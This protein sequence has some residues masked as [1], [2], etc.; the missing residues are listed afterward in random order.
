MIGPVEWSLDL[1]DFVSRIEVAPHGAVLAGS[2]SGSAVIVDSGTGTAIDL[3]A[4]SLGVLSGGW[5][6]DAGLLATGGHDGVVRIHSADGQQRAE[7][8]LDGWVNA[9]AWGPRPELLAVAAGRSLR[10]ID[11][12]GQITRSYP[13]AP[14]T[15]TAVRWATTGCRVGV[16]AYGGVTWY[17]PDEATERPARVHEFTG[18][19]LSLE[20][21][22]SGRWACAGYQDSSVHL[23]RLW[24]GDDLSMSGYPSKIEQLAFRDDS[25]WM[26]SACVE[27]ITLWSFAGRGPKGT[28]PA[29]AAAHERHVVAME[30]E[31]NG[32]R[33]L[34]AGADGRVIL[35]PS[36]TRTK[37]ELE[38]LWV[39]H[40][41]EGLASARWHPDGHSVILGYGDGRL[42]C[43]RVGAV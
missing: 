35:W 20:L 11:P 42:E 34:S 4:H 39:M 9:L 28:V 5:N 30:F 27:E 37:Q 15:I 10:I 19:P 29:R 38:P 7:V 25:Q 2:L 33:L 23:W 16:T 3:P 18:S 1:G 13:A 8:A 31:P 24:S 21:S 17:D 43:R 32:T 26:A 14:S 41:E 36:P 12:S 6:S 40:S 22:P